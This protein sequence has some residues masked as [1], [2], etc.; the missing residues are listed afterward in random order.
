[1]IYSSYHKEISV[2]GNIEFQTVFFNVQQNFKTGPQ[3]LFV[4]LSR[5]PGIDLLNFLPFIAEKI[6]EITLKSNLIFAWNSH[7]D[8]NLLV[9]SE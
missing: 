6:L 8:H 4:N 7:H 9:C 1:M 5:S 2:A 3:P